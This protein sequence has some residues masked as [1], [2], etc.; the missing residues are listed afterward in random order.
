MVEMKNFLDDPVITLVVSA[1]LMDSKPFLA[2][3]IKVLKF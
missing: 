1:P 2:D 3:S